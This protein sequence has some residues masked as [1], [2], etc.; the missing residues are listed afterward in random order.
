MNY[1]LFAFDIDNEKPTSWSPDK[2]AVFFS[3]KLNVDQASPLRGHIKIG[4]VDCTEND[5]RG[6]ALWKVSTATIVAGIMA[7]I[8]RDS[9]GDRNRMNQVPI[10]NRDRSLLIGFN[11]DNEKLPLRTLYVSNEDNLIYSIILNFFIATESIFNMNGNYYPV[12]HKTAGVSAIFQVLK[13][14]LVDVFKSETIDVSSVMWVERF[15]SQ[16]KIIDFNDAFLSGSSGTHVGRIRDM[17]LLMAGHKK[18]DYF[19]DKDCYLE[20]ERLWTNAK[21]ITNA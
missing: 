9:Q 5:E 21:V 1:E 19:K 13:L 2:L 18:L 17:L 7:L 11:C 12:F 3:R 4:A 15:Y 10:G 20:Y 8:T 6:L 16:E 14:L